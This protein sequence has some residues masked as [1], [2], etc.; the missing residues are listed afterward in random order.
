MSLTGLFV[1]LVTPFTAAGE[2]ATAAL[3]RLAWSALD[4][5]AT[6]L[7]ALGTTA[8]SANLTPEE[9]RKVVDV[10]AAACAE[11]RAPLIVGTGSNSTTQSVDM[12]AGVDPRS[13]AV[14]AVVPYYSRPSEDGVVEHFRQLAE[15]SPV[16]LVVYHIPCRTGMPLAAT[17]LARLAHLP[18]IVGFKHS[19]G[20]ID[21]VTVSFM[22]DVA[23]ETSVLAG[24]DLYA[25]PLL[26]LGASGA[27]LAAANVA[28][29]SYA[30]LVSAWLKGPNDRALRLHNRLVPLT[31]ALFAEPNPVVIKAVL[32]ARGQIPSPYVRLPLLEAGATATTAALDR[33]HDI[34]S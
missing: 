2:V 5:G 16:P 3:E 11:R 26:A 9:R 8:E 22:S 1:P 12:L 27:I 20:G 19:V 30:D 17:T 13:T 33:C 24:D 25:A 29:R 34:A 32:A 21:D 14:L 18:N 4:D 15:A 28:T 31:R 7:V 10:C 23:A 6:G